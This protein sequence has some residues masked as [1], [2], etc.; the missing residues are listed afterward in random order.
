VIPQEPYVIEFNCHSLYSDGELRVAKK[1]QGCDEHRLAPTFGSFN[2]HG[3]GEYLGQGCTCC[4]GGQAARPSSRSAPGTLI[5]RSAPS[6]PPRTALVTL[7]RGMLF[8]EQDVRA[9]QASA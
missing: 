4:V 3:L 2:I 5:W 7:I 8:L 1:S 6:I 9:P